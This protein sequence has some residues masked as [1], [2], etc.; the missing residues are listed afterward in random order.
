[1]TLTSY[2][3]RSHPD[4]LECN[5]C[6]KDLLQNSKPTEHINIE[7]DEYYSTKTEN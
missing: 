6:P 5:E 3:E 7:H 1:M 2:E 4:I